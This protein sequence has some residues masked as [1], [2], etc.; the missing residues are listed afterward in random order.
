MT[1]RPWIPCAEQLP[2]EGL[3][4]ETQTL[5]GS[6]CSITKKHRWSHGR[7]FVIGNPRDWSMAAPIRWRFVEEAD[8]AK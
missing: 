3:V 6:G 1:D 4:V 8:A 5:A 7:W 2:P